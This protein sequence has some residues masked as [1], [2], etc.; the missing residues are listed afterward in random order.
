MVF[1]GSWVLS[2]VLVLCVVWVVGCFW[3]MLGGLRRVVF[4][5]VRERGRDGSW[6]GG[7]VDGEMD[8]E[9]DGWMDS[10]MDARLFPRRHLNISF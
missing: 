3:G 4:D 10:W 8:G 1:L 7:E 2:L 5:W 9:M 6:V